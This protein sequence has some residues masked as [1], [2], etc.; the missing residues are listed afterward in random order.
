V[1]V[2][3]ISAEIE[4]LTLPKK[5]KDALT[6]SATGMV[7]KRFQAMSDEEC[8]QFFELVSRGDIDGNKLG[9][10][11]E[12]FEIRQDEALELG[13][14]EFPDPPCP[15]KPRK[16]TAVTFSPSNSNSAIPTVADVATPT[17]KPRM[18]SSATLPIEFF[19]TIPYSPN[20]TQQC[21]FTGGE[22]VAYVKK[23]IPKSPLPP[24]PTL[25]KDTGKIVE[26]I[27][28]PD[29]SRYLARADGDA[30]YDVA[31]KYPFLDH[32]IYILNRH[33]ALKQVAPTSTGYPSV[34]DIDMKFESVS[35]SDVFFF[36]L[37]ACSLSGLL[38]P[39]IAKWVKE[40]IVLSAEV[41]PY[42]A[43]LHPHRGTPEEFLMARRAYTES[44]NPVSGRSKLYQRAGKLGCENQQRCPNCSLLNPTYLECRTCAGIGHATLS[45]PQRYVDRELTPLITNILQNNDTA[46]YVTEPE[47]T[48]TITALAHFLSRVWR[49]RVTTCGI[50]DI[51]RMSGTDAL[52]ESP[53]L[54]VYGVGTESQ[55]T[56]VRSAVTSRALSRRRTIVLVRETGGRQ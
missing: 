26:G 47:S 33:K 24:Y 1:N 49:K 9:S 56:V 36:F 30:L 31:F 50:S 52:S 7:L 45:A 21:N 20:P 17:Q 19:G 16:V 22:S 11:L 10:M 55:K 28:I 3:Q 43:L 46:V 4:K 53:V 38:K 12:V 8:A 2:N 27:A 25:D 32:S 41:K 18:S 23:L 37:W 14:E 54:I 48:E 51:I 34:R 40:S 39:E 44:V 35:P 5:I 6:K 13:Q 29:V 42:L 15:P